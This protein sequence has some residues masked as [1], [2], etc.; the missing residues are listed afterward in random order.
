M[1][2]N[3]QLCLTAYSADH[4]TCVSLSDEDVEKKGIDRARALRAVEDFHQHKSQKI[5]IVKSEQ[6]PKKSKK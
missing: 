1:E 2:Q 6:E 4:I 5:E 3:T